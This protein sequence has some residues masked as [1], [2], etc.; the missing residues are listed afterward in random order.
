MLPASSCKHQDDL[1]WKRL[2]LRIW[3]YGYIYIYI[4][5]YIYIIIFYV[6]IYI[7]IRVCVL[8]PVKY[9]EI[10]R[11]HPPNVLASSIFPIPG[12]APAQK[13]PRKASWFRMSRNLAKQRPA[14]GLERGIHGIYRFGG[15]LKWVYPNS[16]MIYKGKSHLEMDDDCV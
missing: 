1:K 4:C 15:F 12:G 6:Y 8:C 9:I 13:R 2:Y 5:I 10:S 11:S 7:Y 3:I 16:W 14:K